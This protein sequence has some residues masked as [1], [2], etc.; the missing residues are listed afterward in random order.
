MLGEAIIR[1]FPA[2]RALSELTTAGR[3]TGDI[4]LA[5]AQTEAEFTEV[6][7]AGRRFSAIGSNAGVA[8]V[9]AVPTTAAA[10]GLYNADLNKSLVID[11]VTFFLLSGTPV[12]GGTILGCQASYGL[13]GTVPVAAGGSTISNMSAG[14]QFSKT[15]AFVNYAMPALLGQTA[16]WFVMPGQQGQMGVGTPAASVG[17]T[18]NAD[19]RGRVIVPPTKI[20]GLTMLAGAGT[21]PL[22][23]PSVEW[24]EAELDLE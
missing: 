18:W 12:S 21:S 16:Q 14:G 1:R 8:P 22:Y 10:W 20:L 24:Y 5:A 13:T 2:A 6:T 23:I 7:R 11:Y 17:G 4:S 19:V 9:Q 15:V 3:L